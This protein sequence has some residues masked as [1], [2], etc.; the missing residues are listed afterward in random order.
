MVFC[1]ECGSKNPENAQFCEN[2]GAKLEQVNKIKPKTTQ[3]NQTL[4]NLEEK[5]NKLNRNEKIITGAGACILGL[6]ILGVIGAALPDDSNLTDLQLYGIDNGD[7][8]GEYQ[9]QI[10]NNT[11]EYE[12]KG[13]TETN[14]TITVTA[15]AVNV[16]NQPVKVN[17]SNEFDYKIKIPKNVNEVTVKIYANKPGKDE[18]YIELTIKRPTPT[19]PATQNTKTTPTA[20]PTTQSSDSSSSNDFD[21]GYN[22]AAPWAQKA[23]NEGWDGAYDP[24]FGGELPDTVKQK[25]SEEQQGFITGYEDYLK[26]NGY[27]PP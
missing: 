16:T 18:S 11:T 5:W 19:Q 3:T 15:E 22:T 12:I 25:S 24:N 23:I 14:A 1:P 2:C 4:K 8:D 10:D 27:W 26:E 17:A 13:A 20:T 7:N 6:L 21:V 9:V